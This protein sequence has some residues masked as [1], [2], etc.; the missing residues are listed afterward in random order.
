MIKFYCG[1]GKELWR[2]A[3]WKHIKFYT[4][5]E[6]KARLICSDCLLEEA[7]K[8]F[9][10]CPGCGIRLGHRVGCEHRRSK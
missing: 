2:Y 1:C 5:E 7:R 9:P 4:L 10:P 8:D 3:D 6:V